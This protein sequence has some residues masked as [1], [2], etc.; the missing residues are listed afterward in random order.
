MAFLSRARSPLFDRLGRSS[1]ATSGKTG[2][3]LQSRA[4][5][6]RRDYRLP[7][8]EAR[9]PQT[10][11]G[12]FPGASSSHQLPRSPGKPC[13]GVRRQGEGEG[14]SGALGKSEFTLKY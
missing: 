5:F 4:G 3:E 6:G 8:S 9:G 14:G 1:E 12:K 7:Q 11:T 2:I 13:G 10:W